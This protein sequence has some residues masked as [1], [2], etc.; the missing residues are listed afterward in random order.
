LLEKLASAEEE[1]ETG[2]RRRRRM[3]SRFMEE[4]IVGIHRETDRDDAV[5]T[6][7]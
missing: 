7:A 1:E 2:L 6:V 4:Q 3:K 5:V